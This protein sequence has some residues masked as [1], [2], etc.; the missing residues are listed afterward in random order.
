VDFVGTAS[1]DL[2]YR[3]LRSARVLVCV[4]EQEASGLPVMEALSAGAAVVASDIPVHREAAS[5]APDAPVV[6]V[7]AWGSPLRIADAI[8]DA[9]RMHAPASAALTIPSWDTVVEATCALYE[10]LL[11]EGSRRPGSA[12]NGVES[13]A[14]AG[15]ESAAYA[16]LQ[17]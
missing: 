10:E 7:P 12:P 3:W 2:L 9:S 1:D 6:F 17:G 8:C 4:A 13:D 11:S 14:L 16:G 15:H 5:W